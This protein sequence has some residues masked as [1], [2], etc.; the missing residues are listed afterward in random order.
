[1]PAIPI[2]LAAGDANALK[3]KT[4]GP[5]VTL[6]FFTS[7]GAITVSFTNGSPFTDGS[8]GFTVSDTTGTEKTTVSTAGT[9]NYTAGDRTGDIDITV[10]F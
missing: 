6:K 4:V 10:A 1:M 5:G 8:T 2:D 7:G 9:Y 3:G